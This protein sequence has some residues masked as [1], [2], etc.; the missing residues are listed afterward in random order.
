MESDPEAPEAPAAAAGDAD[1]DDTRYAPLEEG[2]VRG[3][4]VTFTVAGTP[5]D[6]LDMILDFDQEPRHRPWRIRTK[7]LDTDGARCRVEAEYE[8]KAGLNPVVVL[9]HEASAVAGGYL[10]R[11]HVEEPTFGLSTFSGEYEM[12][13]GD[14]ASGRPGR[15][16][17]RERVFIDSGLLFINATADDIRAALLRDAQDIRA[18]MEA[19]LAEGAGAS[20]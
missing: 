20:S 8:G 3:G 19:R 2:G 14:A 16:R 5:E 18:W 15:S 7:V 4:E 6:L 13:A 12:T 1:G 17:F 11:F 10:V 9:V